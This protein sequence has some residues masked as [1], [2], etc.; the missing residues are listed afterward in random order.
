VDD[1]RRADTHIYGDA[2]EISLKSGRFEDVDGANISMDGY[3]HDLPE[4]RLVTDTS[5]SSPHPPK[6]T[7][8]SPQILSTCT[9]YVGRDGRRYV[10]WI[11]ERIGRTLIVDTQAKGSA[12]NTS[13]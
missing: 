11:A 10:E 2:H 3:M 8:T 6:T 7:H 5:Q 12:S 9:L 1:H 13:Q 4:G